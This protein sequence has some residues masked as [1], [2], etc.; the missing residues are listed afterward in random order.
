MLT[1]QKVLLLRKVD[2]FTDISTRELGHLAH[3]AREVVFPA[4]ST[5][6]AEGDYGDALFI[7]AEGEVTVYRRGT[8]ISSLGETDYFGEVAILTGE[9][10]SAT[11]KAASDCLL[12]R[13][14]QA[15][16]QR[17]LSENFEAVLA[18]IRTL[19]RRLRP[20]EKTR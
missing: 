3:I 16:F 8:P 18:V 15:E 9:M 5:I 6:I 2:L 1:V 17:V 4:G 10:R 14:D 12:L 7:I 13:I 19:S 11:I 20:S